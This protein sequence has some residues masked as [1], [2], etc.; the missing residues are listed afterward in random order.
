MQLRHRLQGKILLHVRFIAARDLQRQPPKF[1]SKVAT[2]CRIHRVNDIRCCVYAGMAQRSISLRLG[3]LLEIAIGVAHGIEYLHDGCDSR[4]LH[5]DIKPQNLL[6]VLNFNP[7]I[8]DFE[9]AKVFYRIQKCSYT[10]T[11]ARGPHWL[12]CSRD[13]LEKSWKSFL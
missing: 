13:I 11:R 10:M 1:L 12:H 4:I 3:K 9:L 6:L 7:N 8:S 2:I 5:C